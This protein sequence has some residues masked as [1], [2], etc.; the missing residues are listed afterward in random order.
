MIPGFLLAWFAAC[1][2]QPP[3]DFTTPTAETE[4]PIA[5]HVQ[6]TPLPTRFP[7]APGQI[8]EY[9][10]QSG[11]T[12][13]TVAAHF[14]TT[15]VE[16]RKANPDL[17]RIVTTL[18]PGRIYRIPAYFAP[19][20]GTPFQI[21]PDSEV[22]GG[23]SV[24]GSSVSDAVTTRSGWLKHYSEFA[25]QQP[26]SGW[27]LVQKVARDYS[28]NPRLLLAL[29]EYRS[30]A[31]S[32]DD[33]DGTLG[34]YP[35]GSTGET[36]P[37]VAMQLSWV[38]E[39]L[40]EGYYGWRTGSLRVIELADSRITRPDSWQNAGTVAVQ[41]LLAKWF[42]QE[43]FD[44]AVGP[45]G[46]VQIYRELFGDPFA[47]A[48]EIIPGELQQPVLQLP[49]EPG[50]VWGYTGGPHPVWGEGLPWA[51]VDF[52]PPLISSGC[53]DTDVWATAMADGVVARSEP[54]LVI[55]DL[56]KDGDEHT[57]WT[58]LY[59]HLA[60]EGRA[61]QGTRVQA[62]GRI[63]H[64]SCEGGRATGTHIHVARRLNGEWISAAGPLAFNLSNWIVGAGAN[65]YDGTLSYFL[66]TVLRA[67]D[68][69]NAFN[70][71]S[72]FPV[73]TPIP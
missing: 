28:L 53:I 68:C 62:G 41:Y 40:N 21:L 71:I 37:G 5:G 32:Q 33:P 30:H 13:E 65:P 56:D 38:A 45:D 10:A 24:S 72:F 23:P 14:N 73:R 4:Q 20:S 49:F 34:R 44:Q 50:M 26:L 64:P 1:A 57:G 67:C 15:I 12:L 6:A 52:A 36:F 31:L 35:L 8:M 17:P 39:T 3:S 63:G 48:V 27:E 54:A 11:D 51:A 43:E 9:A 16:I 22:V 19:F 69:I 66:D 58:I 55:L 25:F 60:K 7:L 47:H 59:Y 2:P 42:N 18:V 46:F 29:L 61:V 70:Q